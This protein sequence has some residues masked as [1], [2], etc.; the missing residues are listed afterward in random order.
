MGPSS[1]VTKCRSPWINN[2]TMAVLIVMLQKV[3]WMTSSTQI[4]V[5]PMGIIYKTST[6]VVFDYNS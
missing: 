1:L 3:A 6:S 5:R 4:L 2:S